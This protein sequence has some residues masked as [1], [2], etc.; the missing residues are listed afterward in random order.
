MSIYTAH[1]HRKTSNHL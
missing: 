1:R